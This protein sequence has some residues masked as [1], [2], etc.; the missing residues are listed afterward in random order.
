MPSIWR[1][2]AV[3][4]LHTAKGRS[5]CRN[6]P[7]RT[8]ARKL[9][10]HIHPPGDCLGQQQAHTLVN[11]AACLPSPHTPGSTPPEPFLLPPTHGSASHKSKPAS[12]PPGKPSLA[13]P[14]S[15]QANTP[16]KKFHHTRLG[17]YVSRQKEKGDRHGRG[18][19]QDAQPSKG[20]NRLPGEGVS[21]AIPHAD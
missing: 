21:H 7:Q 11:A 3:R 15:H 1:H 17:H 18:D 2:D 6:D 16:L 5:K 20:P 9:H 10:A 19:L 4:V 8:E 13:K 12:L 14:F